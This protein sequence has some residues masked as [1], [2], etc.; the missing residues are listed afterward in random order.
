[1]K[2]L[3]LALALLLSLGS[4]LALAGDKFPEISTR[5]LKKAIQAKKVTLLDVNGTDSYRSGHIPGALDYLAIK[6][7][8]A[9]KLPAYKHALIVAYC[10]NEQCPAYR[11]AAVAAVQLGYTNVKHYAHG[12]MGWTQDGE[13]T[14]KVN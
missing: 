1:M 5:A 14:E 4:V 6:E 11:A 12:I 8:L 7:S 9:A 13:P 2:K 10:G 3:L